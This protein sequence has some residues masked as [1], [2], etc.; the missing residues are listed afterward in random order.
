MVAYFFAAV[1]RSAAC[2]SVS[3]FDGRPAVPRGT[4]QSSATLRVTKSRACA[5]RMDWRKI[6]RRRCRVSVLSVLAFMASHSSTSSADS[7]ASFRAPVPGL[8]AC[9]RGWSD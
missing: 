9:G 8:R 1:S 4:S 2:A 5:R 3:D 6:D 7:C